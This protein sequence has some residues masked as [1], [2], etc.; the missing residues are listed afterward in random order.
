MKNNNIQLAF[1]GLF[2]VFGFIVALLSYFTNIYYD[3]KVNDI[4]LDKLLSQ[5]FKLKKNIIQ[6]YSDEIVNDIEV[7]NTSLLFTEY[8]KALH[9]KNSKQTEKLLIAKEMFKNIFKQDSKYRQIRFIDKSGQEVINLKR[10]KINSLIIDIPTSLM[11]NKKDRYYFKETSKLKDHQVWISKLDLNIE[12]NQIEIPYVPTIRISTPVYIKG[13]F[14]GI[15]IMNTFADILLNKLVASQLFKISLIDKEGYFIIGSKKTEKSVIDL[16]WSRYLDNSF[17]I[18]NYLPQYYNKI[19]KVKEF[20]YK[21]VHSKDFSNLIQIPEG[22]IIMM[23]PLDETLENLDDLKSD[24]ILLTAIVIFIISIPIA[25]FLARIPTSLNQNLIKVKNE[26]EASH[27]ELD[28]YKHAMDES[29]I[30]SKSDLN[31]NI[32]YINDKFTEVSGYTRE[33]IIGKPHSILRSDETPQ[34]TFK[35]LWSSVQK[36]KTWHGVLKNKKKNGDFY[37]VN[38]TIY[39]ILNKENEITE[40]IAI[41]HEVTELVKNKQYLEK[42]LETDSLTKEGNRIKLIRDIKQ[43]NKP[44]LALM[45]IVGFSEINDFYGHVLGDKLLIEVSKYI[46]ENIKLEKFFL[47]RLYSDQFAILTFDED[48]ENFLATMINFS[49]S[50]SNNKF[51]IENKEINITTTCCISMEEKDFLISTA[52]MAKTFAKKENRI[53]VYNEDMNLEKKYQNNIDWQ[54]KINKALKE[55]KIVPYFQPILNNKTNKIEKYEC[56]MRLL[57]EN[58]TAISPYFFLDIAKK[59]KQYFS[60]TKRMI[61]ESFEYFKDKD[62][63]FSINITV[64]DILNKEINEFIFKT[65]E[66]YNIS[67]KVVLEMVESEEIENFNVIGEFIRKVEALGCKLAIDDFGTG[68][69]NFEYLIKLKADYIKIDGSMIK[70]IDVNSD[71]EAIVKTIVLF[72][73]SQ[74][75]KT[76][77]EYVSNEK[78]YNKINELGIDYSQGFYISEPRK[79]I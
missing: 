26:I 29:N 73:K 79:S 72:A 36:K 11:Q 17:K 67:N 5:E 24:Q 6:N 57:D 48:S 47:Y 64:E 44:A 46:K 65:L 42:T 75:L 63:E 30:I 49:Q 20:S 14:Q 51:K 41:R 78:I 15:L 21:K 68:Y 50:L 55:N 40:Y 45:D 53:V 1:T 60:L 28:Q 39:P 10:Q 2:L 52:T 8:I 35:D 56:L 61:E 58:N 38:I 74:G 62:I 12:N 69:S 33:D 31:G 22:F 59:S 37:Y 13:E 9:T 4:K 25:L 19:T 3:D 18:S 77:A 54:Y 71:V 43:N 66:K 32:I 16:S 7:L 34:E 70:D 27:K 76:I 23:E